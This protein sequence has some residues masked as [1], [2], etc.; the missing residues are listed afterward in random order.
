MEEKHYRITWVIDVEASSPLEAI[1]RAI[2]YM[3]KELNTESIPSYGLWS[4]EE[5]EIDLSEEE[6]DPARGYSHYETDKIFTK[7]DEDK[8]VDNLEK[9]LWNS[10]TGTPDV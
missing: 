10:P 5:L 7:P 3:P 1:K 6:P 4:V 9:E 8:E 2:E